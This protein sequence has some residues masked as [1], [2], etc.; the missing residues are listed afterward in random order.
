MRRSNHW[1]VVASFTSLALLMADATSAQVVRVHRGG[2]GNVHVRAPFVDVHVGPGGATSVRA[3]FTA[4]DSPGRA[5]VGRGARR[6]YRH[7]PPATQPPA[8]ARPQSHAPRYAHPTP[9]IQP[10]PTLADPHGAD[11]A[12]SD[13]AAA[14]VAA[15]EQPFPTAEELAAMDEVTLLNALLYVA[16]EFDRQLGRFNTGDTWRRYLGLPDEA[17]PPPAA[18]GSVKLGMSALKKTLARF[19]KVAANPKYVKINRL[20]GFVAMQTALSQVVARF[21]RPPQPSSE[22]IDAPAQPI[23][24]PRLPQDTAPSTT[25]ET[26]PTPQEQPQQQASPWHRALDSE[27]LAALLVVGVFNL[28]QHDVVTS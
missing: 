5:Y 1:I 11:V 13:V 20:D 6:Y 18:D 7:A 22:A 27:A 19:D 2:G 4:V 25:R 8:A 28:D 14:D 15:A 12:S 24:E 21:D 26:Q 3:P 10:G 23:T 17:L 9:A 16:E